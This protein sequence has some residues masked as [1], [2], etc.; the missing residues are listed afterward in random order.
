M[1]PLA[2][3]TRTQAETDA[4]VKGLA[5][6]LLYA[7]HRPSLGPERWAEL[8]DAVDGPSDVKALA[9]DED[10]PLGPFVDALWALDSD[11]G[12][13]DGD[14]LAGFA[15]VAVER[16]ATMYQRVTEHLEA[17]PGR[18]LELVCREIHPWFFAEGSEATL[19]QS[20]RG[21]ATV[22]VS[23]PLPEAFLAGWLRGFL[24]LTGT[25]AEVQP[26][27]EGRFRLAWSPMEAERPHRLRVLL[28]ATRARFL[29]ATLAPILVGTAVA[30]WA[31]GF[32]TGLFALAL[33]GAASLHL[34]FNL[35]NDVLDHRRGVDPANL[36][37]TPFSGGS[38]V[39]QRGWLGSDAMLGLAAGLG[40]VGAGVGLGLAWQ[41]GWPV[42]ALGAA[43][44]GL[45]YAYSG[46][47]FRLADR[48]LGEL[49]AALVF[50]P[51]VTAG[52]AAVQTGTLSV[53]AFAAG[54]PLGLFMAS[55]LM[56]NELPDAP[57]D[58]RMGRRTLVVR[59]G[60]A[61][62]WGTGLALLTPYLALGAA[63]LTTGLPGASLLGLA[64]LPFALYVGHRVRVAGR[65]ADELARLQGLTL[66]LYATTGALMAMGIAWEVLA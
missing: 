63:V 35:L 30:A 26:L 4:T 24:E 39:I 22:R 37:P 28:E 47:P 10:R 14:Q 16:W 57:W 3:T 40:L 41:A 56:V 29:P 62:S 17:R 36:T 46:A 45:G 27:G 64:T 34:A 8:V 5:W 53:P 50:G 6:K 44:V 43:G 60:E 2:L 38:R 23:T 1:S 19:E 32:S 58:A 15:A 21:E 12:T 7:N 59:L 54:A 52:G 11:L 65:D 48:G 42:L 33:T 55:F 13:G 20:R 31:D 25:D 51:L 49:T 61:A 9:L 66:L 18:M